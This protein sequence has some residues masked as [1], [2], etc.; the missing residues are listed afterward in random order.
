MKLW[1]TKNS[2]VS[3]NEQ[4]ATQVRLGIAA[5]DLK[6]GEKLPST[7]ELARRFAIHANTVSAAYSQLTA[8]G[9]IEF[10]KGSGVFVAGTTVMG[11]QGNLDLL[12][13]RFVA[14][15]SEAGSTI[16]EIDLAVERWRTARGRRKILVFEPDTGLR[17]ILVHELSIAVDSEIE[18]CDAEALAS[19]KITDV[20]VGLADE[21]TR[22]SAIVRKD[23]GVVLLEPNSPPRSL[24]GSERPAE[25]QLVAVVSCW[26]Q[27]LIFARVY[28]LAAR[29]PPEALIVRQTS[30]PDWRAGIDAAAVIVCDSLTAEFF[31]N[32][33]RVRSFRLIS[34]TSLGKVRRAL[35]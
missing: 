16:E 6:P 33:P 9:L 11:P 23:Q 34:D 19:C 29:I 14:D 7:R 1:I 15:A 21:Q 3:I 12:F 25:D 20:V 28:L 18:S 2:E 22:I 10:R 27:F 17:S 30:Q 31:P 5:G 32:D 4:L 26:N 24:L 35:L 13:A 8:E